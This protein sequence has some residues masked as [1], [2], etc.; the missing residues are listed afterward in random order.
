MA[1]TPSSPGFKREALPQDIE[2]YR[3]EALKNNQA[4]FERT[5]PYPFL[6]YVRSK[7]WDKSLLMAQ[8]QGGGMDA[9]A[10]RMVKYEFYEGGYTFLHPVRKRQT[11][12]NDP[13]I[14]LGRST[15]TETYF[16]RHVD[17]FEALRELLLRQWA[18]QPPA[19]FRAWCAGCSS[20]EEPLSVSAMLEEVRSLLPAR[21]AVSIPPAESWQSTS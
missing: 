8:D 5:V 4:A 17:Q 12:P 11:N 3:T 20:G 13:A 1:P 21:P 16:F 19:T 14:I 9:G 2:P 7:L 18:T 15:N 10:T 6:L